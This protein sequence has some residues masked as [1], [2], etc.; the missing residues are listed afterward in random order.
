MNKRIRL[1]GLASK[2]MLLKRSLYNHSSVQ[3]VDG[4]EGEAQFDRRQLA[5]QKQFLR[6]SATRSLPIKQA[7]KKGDI[8]LIKDDLS[9]SRARE[10]HIVTS[11][12]MKENNQIMSKI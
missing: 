11:C 5:N 1:N 7:F 8:V 4:E 2:E 10:R 6:D 3:V 9:K 12:F